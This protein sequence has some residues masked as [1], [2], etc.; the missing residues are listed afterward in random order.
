MANPLDYTSLITSEHNQQPNY[1]A[2]LQV[3]AQWAA[4]RLN[5]LASF[6]TLFDIDTAMG[7]QLDK[8]GNWIGVS[9]NIQAAG[10]VQTLVVLTDANYRVLLKSKILS[11]NWD[12]TV[13]GAYAVLNS[14]FALSPTPLIIVDNQD[15]T[16]FVI[17]ESNGG[18]VDPQLLAILVNGTISVKPA[19]V[20][21][22]Y[23]QTS[24]Q[25]IFGLDFDNSTIGGLDHGFMIV[26]VGY[27]F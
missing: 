19:G 21:V 22:F 7:D 6:P 20:S 18:V 26:P 17:I 12:G 16:M 15:M 3:F 9:R 10:S 13:P 1:M 11:N 14:I 5:M 24:G 25:P 23:Y 4:D 8:L 2:M 27:P